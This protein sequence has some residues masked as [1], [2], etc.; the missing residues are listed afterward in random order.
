MCR[1]RRSILRTQ[2]SM[3]KTLP[4]L[5]C[6]QCSQPYQ[7]KSSQGTGAAAKYFPVYCSRECKAKWWAEN[8]RKT[9]MLPCAQCGKIVTCNGRRDRERVRA[10]RVYCSEK[11]KTNLVR[12]ISQRTMARTNRAHA[13]HRMKIRNPMKRPETRAKVSK[14]MRGRT[15]LARGGNGQPTTPQMIMA[16]ATGLAMEYPI[17]T[18]TVKGRFQSLPT[19]YKVDL[20]DPKVKLAVEIDGHSHRTKKWRF[21]D[22]RKTAVLNGLGWTVLRFWNQDVMD[23]L[24]ACVQTVS[25]TILRLRKTTTTSPTDS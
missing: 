11:C 14:A 10:G 3:P 18:A 4:I 12:A 22:Q 6:R 5:R 21:L 24:A 13:S 19:C 25:S 23:D 17:P 20:A 2:C 7:T 8:V 1:P 15:F 9:D 16:N